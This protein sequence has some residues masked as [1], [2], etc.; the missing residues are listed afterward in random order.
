MPASLKD[1]QAAYVSSPYFKN[2]YL[3]LL[4]N[5]LPVSKQAIRR[6]E[7]AS[8]IHMILD[9][10]FFKVIKDH[11]G[12]YTPLLCIPTSQG[13]VHLNHYHSYLEGGHVEVTKYYMTSSQ[14]FYCLNLTYYIRAYVAGCNSCQMFKE[15]KQ[16]NSPFQTGVNLDT[17]V[18]SKISLDIKYMPGSTKQYKHILVLLCI[19]TNILIA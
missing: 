13:N 11:S 9:T 15:D 4:D 1:L 14:R 19:V 8:K 5:K 16:P 18:L 3:Y 2:L 6:L 17:L 12:E 10:L 7:A